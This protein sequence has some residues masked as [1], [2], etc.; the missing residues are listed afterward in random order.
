M[1]GS[2]RPD[3]TDIQWN[4]KHRVAL[5]RITEYDYFGGDGNR[6]GGR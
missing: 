4:P 2:L 6:A 1:G 3:K 5:R